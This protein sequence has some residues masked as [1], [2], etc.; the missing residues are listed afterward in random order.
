[1]RQESDADTRTGPRRP[2]L[3]GDT[4]VA[5]EMG[6]VA[7]TRWSR[8]TA[9]GSP[10]RGR[11][12][13]GHAAGTYNRGVPLRAVSLGC[14]TGAQKSSEY[15]ISA[16]RLKKKCVRLSPQDLRNLQGWRSPDKA[17]HV[18]EAFRLSDEAASATDAADLIRRYSSEVCAQRS[19]TA[20]GKTV[21]TLTRLAA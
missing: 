2:H 11:V 10:T 9:E 17:G 1:M 16:A 21:W 4:R 3:A 15:G 14:L 18:D 20:E 5:I 7:P 13:A 12:D 8:S 6:P 19:W